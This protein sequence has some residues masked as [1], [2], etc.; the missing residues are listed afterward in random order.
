M[1]QHNKK[2]IRLHCET[3]IAQRM[4]TV[5]ILAAMTLTSACAA[6]QGVREAIDT[7][8]VKDSCIGNCINGQ[9]TLTRAN[10]SKYIGGFKNG[11]FEGKGTMIRINGDQYTM[12]FKDGDMVEPKQMVVVFANGNKYVGDEEKG[13]MEFADGRKYVGEIKNGQIGRKGT[14]TFA[15]GQKYVGEW[16]NG[17]AIEGRGTWFLADGSRYSNPKLNWE[18]IAIAIGAIVASGAIINSLSGD[19]DSSDPLPNCWAG[20]VQGWYDDGGNCGPLRNAVAR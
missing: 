7:Y 3:R 20:V 10:G 2:H 9:G 16:E 1:S 8:S 12:E 14:M 11:K 19:S 6:Q 5:T 18:G 17:K 4:V 13:T 15:D